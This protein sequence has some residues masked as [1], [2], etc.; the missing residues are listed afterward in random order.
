M[1]MKA[2]NRITLRHMIEI[3]NA[4]ELNALLEKNEK[5]LVLFY[6]TWCPFCVNFVPMFDK[7]IVNYNV[8]SVIHVLLDDYDNQLWDDYDVE[9]V[10]T[11]IF[12]EKSKVE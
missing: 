9:A 11:V 2:Q 7:K 1:F 6:A 12:F 5:V 8:G 3:D 4:E 10:P